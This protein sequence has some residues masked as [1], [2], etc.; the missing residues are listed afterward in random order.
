MTDIVF[1]R[2]ISVY[3]CLYIKHVRQN[4]FSKSFRSFVKKYPDVNGTDLIRAW[5]FDQYL[6]NQGLIVRVNRVT[7]RWNTNGKT[8]LVSEIVRIIESL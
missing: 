5:H 3:A 2:P 7:Y 4:G 1:N 6:R 8:I